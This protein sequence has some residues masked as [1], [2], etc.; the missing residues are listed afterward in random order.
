MLVLLLL[1]VL[2][3]AATTTWPGSHGFDAVPE[4]D[5]CVRLLRRLR[6]LSDLHKDDDE[7]IVVA[8]AVAE[9]VAGGEE[10]EEATLEPYREAIMAET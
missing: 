2:P 6:S 9:V 8:V 1:L 4:N 3:V 7:V 5:W 10:E